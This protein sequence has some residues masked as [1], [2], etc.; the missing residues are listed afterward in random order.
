M[1]DWEVAIEDLRREFEDK[2]ED[3]RREVEDLRD[4]LS[5]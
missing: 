5:D 2:F 4:R 3:L 1:E